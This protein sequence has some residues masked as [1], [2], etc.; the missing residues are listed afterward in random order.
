MPDGKVKVTVNLMNLT[1]EPRKERRKKGEHGKRHR[2]LALFNSKLRCFEQTGAFGRSTFRQ[3]PKDFR[4]EHVRWVWATG[5]NCVARRMDASENLLIE[6]IT[7]ET[8]P[9][10]RQRR[11]V[12]NADAQLEPPFAEL[13]GPNYLTALRRVAAAMDDFEADWRQQL[14]AW[15][16]PTTK[17]AC[18]D[19]L[20]AFHDR[21]VAGFALGIRCLQDD[22]RLAAAFRAANEAFARS[23]AARKNPI[24]H[25]R[26]F[27]VVYQVIQLAGLR[28]RESDDP[29]LAAEL[30]RVDVLWFP[31]GGGKT[32]A[33][34]GLIICLLFYDRLRG[35]V[36]GVSAIL[37]FPLAGRRAWSSCN[38]SSMCCGSPNVTA[39]NCSRRTSPSTTAITTANGRVP[40][41]L[42]GR[43]RQQ[44]QQPRGPS[45]P[46]RRWPSAPPTGRTSSPTT[47][48]A[49]RTRASSRAART[50]PATAAT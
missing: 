18:T 3:A 5:H 37:R 44:P 12:P 34:L 41:G 11:M 31:T 47:P 30:D 46:R 26:L 33:Y 7:T 24:T 8:W 38:A 21:D 6:P 43:A 32:E 40:A 42:L 20:K 48:S 29:I 23:G 49:R 39:A 28:A 45:P 4:D 22:K 50:R 25:W 17:Q 27:Q 10:Y 14:A 15:S 13:A 16:D 36:R 9:C 19:A 1:I 35:K 2:E